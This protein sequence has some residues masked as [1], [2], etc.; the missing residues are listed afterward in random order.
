MAGEFAGGGA[1]GAISTV[2]KE[3]TKQEKTVIIGGPA[4]ENAVLFLA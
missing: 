3:S 1:V 2:K 4:K